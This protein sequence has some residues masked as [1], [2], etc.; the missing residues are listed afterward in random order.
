MSN[1]KFSK[2]D[3][4]RIIVELRGNSF[5]L[6]LIFE[7]GKVDVSVKLWSSM[8]KFNVLIRN[9]DVEKR[10]LIVLLNNDL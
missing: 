10:P 4:F 6:L 1:E 7:Q 2:V 5:K 8:L 3:D 9:V